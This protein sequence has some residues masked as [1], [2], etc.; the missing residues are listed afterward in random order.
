MFTNVFGII[1]D[2][3]NCYAE[4]KK[5]S[6]ER[7][8]SISD[9]I[10]TAQILYDNIIEAE[11]NE[12]QSLTNISRINCRFI[13]EFYYGLPSDI[14]TLVEKRDDLTPVEF[15]QIVE[16]A[17][18]KLEKKYDSQQVYVAP[19]KISRYKPGG[20]TRTIS[21]Y[22]LYDARKAA[23]NTPRRS[24]WRNYRNNWRDSRKSSDV[25]TVPR[26]R[27]VDRVIG[28]ELRRGEK[29]TKLE[30]VSLLQNFRPR[31]RGMSETGI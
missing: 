1:R 3:C 15:Y 8:Q 27:G 11:K 6:A 14:R 24:E 13:N 26:D 7:R 19:Y 30:A 25:N 12:K 18:Y 9:Y 31:N 10:G 4:L 29:Q 16:K 5:L 2:I 28:T 22:T 20:K 23:R 17:N 21:S